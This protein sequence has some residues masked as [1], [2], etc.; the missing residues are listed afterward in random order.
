LW[1][2]RDLKSFFSL[3]IRTVFNERSFPTGSSGFISVYRAAGLQRRM[4]IGT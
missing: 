1:V 2:F 4:P 3:C